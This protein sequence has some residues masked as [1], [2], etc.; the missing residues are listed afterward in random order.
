MVMFKLVISL[1]P[2]TDK[3]VRIDRQ[4]YHKIITG[5]YSKHIFT[6]ND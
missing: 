5:Q 4:A 1:M 3:H 2:N 6:H